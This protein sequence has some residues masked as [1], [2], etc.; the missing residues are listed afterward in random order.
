MCKCYAASD[1]WWILFIVYY[2]DITVTK[3]VLMIASFMLQLRIFP[4]WACQYLNIRNL[5]HRY[6]TSQLNQPL[7][8]KI[9]LLI[10]GRDALMTKRRPWWANV[11]Q[12]CRRFSNMRPHS[13]ST[14]LFLFFFFMTVLV[15]TGPSIQASH[16]HLSRYLYCWKLFYL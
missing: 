14:A 11:S 7:C 9:M 4:V 5:K 3:R 16:P 6:G 2:F 10:W 8:L 13:Q 15:D 1:M 12:A